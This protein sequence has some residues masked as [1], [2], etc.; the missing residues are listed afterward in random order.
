M[1]ETRDKGKQAALRAELGLLSAITEGRRKDL[2]DELAQFNA[3]RAYA[4]GKASPPDSTTEQPDDG[5]T[6]KPARRRGPKR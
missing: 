4:E 3:R 6:P 1:F 2:E 5:D